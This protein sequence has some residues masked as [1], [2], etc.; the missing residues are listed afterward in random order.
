MEHLFWKKKRSSC[1]IDKLFDVFCND[2]EQRRRLEKDHKLRMT[3]E[4]F[5]FYEDQKSR[6]IGKCLDVALPLIS[7]DQKFIRRSESHVNAPSSQCQNEIIT[8]S[9]TYYVSESKSLASTSTDTSQS[10]AVSQFLAECQIHP[11]KIAKNGQTLAEFVNATS[12]RIEQLM[13]LLTVS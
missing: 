10:S 8:L 2:N 13:Q 11:F 1:H 7:S 4:D 12:Y 6:C 3:D 5:V 9:T